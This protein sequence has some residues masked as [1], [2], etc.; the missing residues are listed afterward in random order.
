[1]LEVGQD[2]ST[3]NHQ[4]TLVLF[5]ESGLAMASVS[6]CPTK[7][8]VPNK[9]RRKQYV[10]VRTKLY[11]EKTGR[12]PTEMIRT[13]EEI[14]HALQEHCNLDLQLERDILLA[15]DD[16][17][18]ISIRDMLKPHDKLGQTDP[19]RKKR[20]TTKGEGESDGE[21]PSEDESVEDGDLPEYED[22]VGIH[23]EAYL[24]L[25]PPCTWTMPALQERFNHYRENP[26]FTSLPP[27]FQCMILYWDYNMPLSQAGIVDSDGNYLPEVFVDV[28]PWKNKVIN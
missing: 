10:G 12:H 14:Y 18:L 3:T 2:P 11:H 22:W 8:Q 26:W 13:F 9:R 16:P 23:T 15:D 19:P 21:P 28:F 6:T 7:I 4:E 5:R 27:R 25:D 24:K 17:L 1:M 20:K